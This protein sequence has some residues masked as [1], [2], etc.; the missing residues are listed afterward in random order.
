[1]SKL[2]INF[3]LDGTKKQVNWYKDILDFPKLIRFQS[4]A[5]EWAIYNSIGG[6]DYELTFS[7]VPSYDPNYYVDMPTFEDMFEYGKGDICECGAIYTSFSWD[8]L[9]Y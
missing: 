2:T 9:R 8:H 4:K 1:M 3:G 5:W 6:T 7:Q